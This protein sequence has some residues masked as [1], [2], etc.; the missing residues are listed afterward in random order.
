MVMNQAFIKQGLIN[1]A[2]AMSVL[3]LWLVISK[4]GDWSAVSGGVFG[5]GWWGVGWSWTGEQEFG[6]F[7]CGFLTAIA[8]V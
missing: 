8:K 4:F 7:F 5:V 6:I 3:L 1:F 2:K